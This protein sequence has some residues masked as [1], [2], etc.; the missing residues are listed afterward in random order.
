MSGATTWALGWCKGKT[1]NDSKHAV[2][3][4][5]GWWICWTKPNDGKFKK[6]QNDSLFIDL[7][8][9]KKFQKFKKKALMPRVVLTAV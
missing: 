2:V 7:L 6:V 8:N 4:R 3:K 1:R 5:C 9:S